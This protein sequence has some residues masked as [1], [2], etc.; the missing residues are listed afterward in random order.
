[1]NFL[2]DVRTFSQKSLRRVE[3]TV[4]T[5]GGQK[6]MECRLDNGKFKLSDTG[7]RCMGFCG[8]YKPDL[9]VACVR[10]WILLSSQDVAADYDLLVEN[11][12]THILN[13]ASLVDNHF[14]D[15]FI[16]LKLE[17]LD[18]PETDITRYFDQCF[19]FIDEA[20][21]SNGVVL[22]HCNAGVSR[23]A[24]III[25]YLMHT[26]NISLEDCLET[27]KEIRPGIRPNA[28]FMSQLQGYEIMNK[29]W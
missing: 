2:R 26:E 11:K 25:G 18:I 8:D 1:M 22:V 14:E 6:F 19:K 5:S 9:Q 20:K 10:P 21:S 3:T 12:V 27:L 13:V 28:G 4:V 23:S 15:D 17:I 29:K 24:S 16:Y 7:E